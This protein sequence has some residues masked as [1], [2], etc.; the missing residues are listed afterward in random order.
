MLLD[1]SCDASVWT[2]MTGCRE[3]GKRQASESNRKVQKLNVKQDY[4]TGTLKTIPSRK[5]SETQ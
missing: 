5:A 4:T 3:N 2:D 1:L